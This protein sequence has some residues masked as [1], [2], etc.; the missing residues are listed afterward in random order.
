MESSVETR[1]GD[2]RTLSQNNRNFSNLG[3]VFWPKNQQHQEL[4]KNGF[5]HDYYNKI[6]IFLFATFKG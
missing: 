5:D 2:A 4:T 6:S 1:T 3:K